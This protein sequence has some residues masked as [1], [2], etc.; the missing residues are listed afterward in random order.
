MASKK[1]RQKYIDHQRSLIAKGVIQPIN[2]Y[3]KRLSPEAKV[4]SR[5]IRREHL[6]ASV[7]LL[8]ESLKIQ[9]NE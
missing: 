3:E 2:T 8:K 6:E 5:L 4:N 9:G 7:R 1:K